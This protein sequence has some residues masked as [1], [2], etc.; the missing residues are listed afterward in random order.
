MQK[1][2]GRAAS[3]SVDISITHLIRRTASR[4]GPWK[5]NM[6][7]ITGGVP[8]YSYFSGGKTAG[9]SV[10]NRTTRTI[11]RIPGLPGSK[12][13]H[14]EKLTAGVTINISIKRAEKIAGIWPTLGRGG[15][16]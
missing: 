11:R 4:V 8:T 9:V 6:G 14:V 16:E 15:G 1:Y 3:G 5:S 10:C 12:A 2:R 7:R 13:R